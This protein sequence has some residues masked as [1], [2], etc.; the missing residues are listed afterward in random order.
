MQNVT[1]RLIDGVPQTGT[2]YSDTL[3]TRNARGYFMRVAYVANGT[4]KTFTSPGT[5]EVQTLTFPAKASA[6]H[7]DLVIV[8]TAAGTKY[9]LAL[10]KKARDVSTITCDTKANSGQGDYCIFYD[11]LGSPWAFALDKAGSGVEPTDMR[12]KVISRNQKVVVNISSATTG[13]DVATL[14][15]TA[16]IALAGFTGVITCTRSTADLLMT[17]VAYAPAT[18]S[19]VSNAAGTGA[20][21]ITKAHTTTGVTNAAPSGALW[22]AVAS[23]RKGL[24]DISAATDAASVAAL[25]ETAFN[26]LTGFTA[27]ITTDDTAADGTITLT[28]VSVGPTTDPVPKNAAESGAG[29]ILGV[30]STAGVATYINVTTNVLTISAHGMLTGET[31]VL[32]KGIGDTYPA[33][34]SGTTYYVIKVDANSLKLSDSYAHAIAGT[35]VVDITDQGTGTFTLTP[36]STTTGTATLEESI[37]GSS[38]EAVPTALA[39]ST[40]ITGAGSHT[41]NVVDRFSNYVRIKLVMATGQ[42]TFTADAQTK[43]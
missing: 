39:A 30:Q 35:N 11:T 1:T 7:Q 12:W 31:V 17:S 37:D 43:G 21:S 24:V 36:N 18:I 34:L 33:G 13:A 19:A 3:D 41:W 20:G 40:A 27:A 23:T 25:A 42:L 4:A 28:Q 38:W 2:V 6:T 26:A 15:R 29:S 8:E 14:V 22:T 9:A 10:T 16:V 5:A 32:S